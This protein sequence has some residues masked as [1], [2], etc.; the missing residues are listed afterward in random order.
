MRVNARGQQL[1]R[2]HSTIP[3][4]A[5]REG[6]TLFSASSSALTPALT[7]VNVQVSGLSLVGL[8][9]GLILGAS[10]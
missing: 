1:S 6:M 9:R 8:S 4:N 10:K 2:L 7:R 5:A 3:W